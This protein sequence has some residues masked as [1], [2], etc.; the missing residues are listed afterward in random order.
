MPV[1]VDDIIRVEA[2]ILASPAATTRFGDVLFVTPDATA[3]LAHFESLAAVTDAG[4]AADTEVYVG[5]SVF[6]G[7]QPFPSNGLLVGQFDPSSGGNNESAA[8]AVAAIKE[9]AAGVGGRGGY[10]LCP[11]PG[12]TSPAKGYTPAQA[13]EIADTIGGRDPYQVIIEDTA[14]GALVANDAVSASALFFDRQNARNSSVISKSLAYKNLALAAHF[15][16]IDL[17]RGDQLR[18]PF[19]QTFENVQ[20][21]V[22]TDAQITEIQRKRANFYS[23]IR[24][25]NSFFNGV[26]TNPAI[27][28]DQQFWL[29]WFV[30]AVQG[31]LLDAARAGIPQ[32]SAG[33]SIMRTTVQQVCENG[34]ANGGITPGV[35]RATATQEIRDRVDPNFDGT[36]TRGYLI[37]VGSFDSL[38]DAQRSARKLPTTRVWMKER[39]FANELDVVAQF[40]N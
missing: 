19:L 30:Q 2:S 21:D 38:T 40:I 28:I 25:V 12:A 5:A 32:N 8:D 33:Q 37:D 24:G 36:L 29:D 6:F 22:F 18:N 9:A 7:Q 16:A 34:I 20:A 35:L 4:Y 39:G 15:A 11:S 17:D 14:A 31:A 1:D 27:W 3:R 10:F 23:P 13:V 26:T